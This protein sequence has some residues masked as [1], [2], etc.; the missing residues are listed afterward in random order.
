MTQGS[1]GNDSGILNA[2]RWRCIGPPRGGRVQAVAG[3][4]VD[5]AVF[6]FGAC[7]GGVWKTDDAGTYWHN[8]TDGQVNTAS[9]GAIAVSDSDPNVIYVGMG[10]AGLRG[11][12]TYGDGV[13]RSTDAGKTW[14]HLGLSDTRHIGRVRIHPTNPDVVY[15]AALGH[16]YGPNEERGVFRSTDGGKNWE[17]VLYKSENAGA[18]DLSMDPN[19]PRILYASIYQVRRNP[20]SLTSGGPD[21][22]IYRTTD[23]GDTWTEITRNKGLPDGLIGRVGIS[24]SAAKSGRVYATIENENCGLF[25]SDDYGD[26]WELATD[27]RDIQG[28]PWYYQHV[29]A[30]PQ[31]ADT[32]WVLN[33]SCWKSIDGGRTFNTV[34]TPHGD[35]HDLWI[36]PRNPRRMIEG[37]DGGANVTFNGGDSWSTIYNQLTSQFYHVIADNRF[38]YHVYGTQQD[39]SA[40]CVPSMT[41]KGAIPWT[42][43]YPTGS[44][45]SGYIA[46]HPNDHNIVVSGSIGSSPGGGGNM[47]HYNHETGQ[48]RIITV[49]PELNTGLGAKEMKYRF[50]WTYPIV[51][52]HHDPD[53][54]YVTGN[55]VFKTRDVGTNWEAVSPDLT[56]AVPE[57][58]EV[59]GGPITKDTSGAET[60]ATIFAFA[61][62]HHDPNVLWAGSDDG[63][64]HITRDGGANWEDITPSDLGEYTLVGMIE[65]SHHDPAT[66]YVAATRYK[67]DENQPILYKTDDYGKTW[68]NISSDIPE[69]D[70][71]RCI[72]EDPVR[73]GMLYVGTETTAYVSFDDG[74]SWQ[75]L[76]AN[77]P[78][79]P[80]HDLIIKEDDLVAATN[81]RSFWIMDDLTQLRQIDDSV[82]GS[83]A[84][85]LKPRD[86]YRPARPFRFREGT[87]GKSYQL[88]LGGAVC[89]YESKD[90][91]GQ[92]ERTF[93]DAGENPPYGPIVTYYLAE[94]PEDE[95]TLTFSDSAGNEIQTFSSKEAEGDDDNKPKR[96]SANAGAN[97]FLWDM[98]YAAATKVPGDKTV[99]EDL[100]GPIAPPGSYQVTLSVG[101]HT[102]TQSFTLVK[103]P[104]VT[105]TQEDFDAQFELLLKIR[106]KLSETH[107]SVLK[108]R[109]VRGQ[110]EEWAKRAEGHPA[111]EAIS[112]SATALNDKLTAIEEDLIQTDYRGAR[113][114]L[115]QPV[116]LNAKLAGLVD[117][118]SSADYAPPTQTQEVY[119]DFASRI[120]PYI[121][122]VDE[123]IEKDVSEFDNL[124]H[125]LEVPTIVPRTS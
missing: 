45:E 18:V 42:D 67:L 70:Y 121:Q 25:R 52:S 10:E 95:L 19:N 24:A 63:L 85:L 34:G 16:A 101:G 22:G 21:G 11:N 76:A 114:R 77:L 55:V 111:E 57:T 72:R 43:C 53:L 87:T 31:D 109:S 116:K 84:R 2:V 28:R 50:Q 105:A 90:E 17:K 48:V 103:D 26:T 8:I 74:G 93:L 96:A 49:W 36:D 47:L 92:T 75:S 51:F 106:D 44:S 37:N 80:V 23:G 14:T 35:N 88:A 108:I 12:V 33:Y 20:W 6:Y 39:N 62:S 27:N 9:V 117:V 61:E 99:S 68:T 4:P 60:Y 125:E 30:D 40:I 13:Y 123:I 56:R 83:A 7:A 107:E 54:L 91:Y 118:V 119:V 100:S 58:L 81:G 64:I 86:T 113:D 69:W 29:F 3:D 79:V 97:R 120:D 112:A 71:T 78:I 66:A 104:R 59:S 32:V 5:P 122:Q 102:E 110:V 115:N 82:T 98:R 124:V 46:V 94:A 15:V 41:H 65:A 1:N 73:A 89:Y 38:P